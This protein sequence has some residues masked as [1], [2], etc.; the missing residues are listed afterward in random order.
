VLAAPRAAQNPAPNP[1]EILMKH[2]EEAFAKPC[3]TGYR[4]GICG[5]PSGEVLFK[6]AARG[7]GR[8]PTC[9]EVDGFGIPVAVPISQVPASAAALKALA[10]PNVKTGTVGNESMPVLVSSEGKQSTFFYDL[11]SAPPV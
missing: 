4:H 11:T 5:G 10:T 9:H 8:C 6:E 7:F 2:G 3:A 1:G